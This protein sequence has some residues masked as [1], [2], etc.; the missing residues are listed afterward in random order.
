MDFPENSVAAWIKELGFIEG[1][2]S[3]HHAFARVND[4]AALIAAKK[5]AEMENKFACLHFLK[6]MNQR[7]NYVYSE[8]IG[9]ENDY[10]PYNADSIA[11]TIRTVD[12]DALPD[13]EDFMYSAK[14]NG[15]Y[16]KR[17]I[18]FLD[19]QYQYYMSEHN[20]DTEHLRDAAKKT[21][22]LSLMADNAMN[23]YRKGAGTSIDEVN[24]VFKM[25]DESAK[26]NMFAA[27]KRKP[28]ESEDGTSFSEIAAKL[29]STGKIEAVK[30]KFPKDDIDSMID[31]Y[32]RI[33]SKL[34]REGVF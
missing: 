24:K 21:C 7:A 6:T 2:L 17:D 20:L 5:R 4:G 9:I 15:L 34:N 19:A 27:C 23:S 22:K 14:W 16:T 29:Q 32:Y 31:E 8:N 25:Y 1:Q 28:G 33:S 26:S 18:E 30:V 12:D 11:G 10:R 13:D 3:Q